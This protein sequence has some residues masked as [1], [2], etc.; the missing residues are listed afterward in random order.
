MA[1]CPDLL[2]TITRLA[3]SERSIA[4]IGNA[5]ARD[6]R[7]KT[8][9]RA[10]ALSTRRLME[11]A[12]AHGGRDRTLNL[13][14]APRWDGPGSQRRCNSPA[15]PAGAPWQRRSLTSRS[16]PR[17]PPPSSVRQARPPH[18]ADPRRT[19]HQFTRIPAHRLHRK[20][21]PP[22]ITCTRS[23]FSTSYACRLAVN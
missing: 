5:S 18:H 21:S 2:E 6:T 16:N 3:R 19:T 9:A 4:L 11:A 1:S 14:S 20:P 17:S 8:R 7:G 13:V 23:M 12:G 22:P 10:E 15:A